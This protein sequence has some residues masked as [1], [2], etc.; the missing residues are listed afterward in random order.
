MVMM[1]T[2]KKYHEYMVTAG[3]G[4]PS[5]TLL[6]KREDWV[7]LLQKVGQL[8][9]YGKEL[10]AWSKLLIKIAEKMIETFDQPDSQSVK[11]CWMKAVHKEGANGSGTV[12][13]LSGWLTAF[14]CWDES[15]YQTHQ[16]RDEETDT[17]SGDEEED[18]SSGDEE[19]AMPSREKTDRWRLVVDEVAFPIIATRDIPR[20]MAEVPVRVL[21]HGTSISYNTTVVAGFVGVESTASKEGE[22]N[23]TFQPRAGYWVLVDKA[24]PMSRRLM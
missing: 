14:C 12:E 23:N 17:F 4:F 9:L 19:T 13:T 2:T 15:G 5:V 1:A 8:A 21:D 3:C 16:Y 22:R 11:D 24:S 7:H 18:M 10:A 20:A 6:G